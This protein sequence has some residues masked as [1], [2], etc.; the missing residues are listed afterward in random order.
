MR[1][2][3]TLHCRIRVLV[4]LASRAMGSHALDVLELRFLHHDFAGAEL[5]QIW[6]GQLMNAAAIKAASTSTRECLFTQVDASVA[7][8]F[9]VT[10]VAGAA[11]RT[12]LLSNT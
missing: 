10:T 11:A 3:Q 6:N 1:F 4:L 12:R 5:K 9:D 2:A 8:L 7:N